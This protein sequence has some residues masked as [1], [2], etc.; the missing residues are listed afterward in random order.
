[1]DTPEENAKS[2]LNDVEAPAEENPESGDNAGTLEE[3]T[4]AEETKEAPAEEAPADDIDDSSLFDE[5]I[6]EKQEKASEKPEEVSLED[7]DAYN[8][9]AGYADV[10][11]GKDF[12]GNDSVLSVDE[13]KAL[14]P[15]LKKLGIEPGKAKDI[16]GVYAA[17]DGARDKIAQDKH[18]KALSEQRK[19]TKEALGEDCTRIM[20]E[21][22]Q[23][24]Q[25]TFPSDL[26][27]LFMST[28]E[29]ANNVDFLRSMAAI[30]HVAQDD[31]GVRTQNNLGKEKNK[32]FT[33]DA[34]KKSSS[35][36]NY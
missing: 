35:E 28:P 2:L 9:A 31:R 15:H 26:A 10:P 30:G 6:E 16:I 14:T 36:V 3:K 12:F 11:L 21:A 29:I 4:P 34:W 13:Q 33:L 19:A 23:G 22:K 25:N 17:L 27:Q 24:I 1:M 7:L 32:P 18:I 5:V 20:K 8:E